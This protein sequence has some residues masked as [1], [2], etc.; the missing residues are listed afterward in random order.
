VPEVVIVGA[1]VAGLAAA[2]ALTT[3]GVDVAVLEARDRIGGRIFTVRTPGLPVPVEL[4]AE[5]L[6]GKAPEV[7]E[8]V[9]PAG[10]AVVEVPD[11][12]R[13]AEGGRFR[14]ARLFDDWKEVVEEMKRFPDPDRSFSDFLEATSEQRG[15]A[16]VEGFHAAR[17]ERISVRSLLDAERSAARICGDRLLRLE[18]GYD[19]VPSLL[20]AGCDA[21]KLSLHRSTVVERV[22]WKP[23][24]VEVRARTASGHAVPSLEAER[25]LF[26][27]PLG[28]M[29]QGPRAHGYVG[30]TPAVPEKRRASLRLE[31]GSVLKVVLRFRTRLWEEKCDPSFAFLHSNDPDFPTWWTTRPVRSTVLTG[32]AGGPVAERLTGRS[33]H[34]VVATALGALA[35]ILDV[36][37]D[38]LELELDAAW[39]HDWQSDPY[40]RGAYSYVPAEG[41]DAPKLLATPVADTLFFAGEATVT[42]GTNGTVHGAI[43]SGQ[44]AALEILEATGRAAVRE[45]AA[46]SDRRRNGAARGRPGSR[47]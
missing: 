19:Q 11:D 32:W 31:M 2:R 15:L 42:D 6:H 47:S 10:R 24:H 28:T 23:G 13:E 9:D 39:V 45:P 44:R 33:E 35:R 5:F 30:L 38:R 46:G 3:S 37:S 22:I 34:E 26:T 14:K 20:L 27:M 43:A 41:K 8:T 17:P 25:V 1:G 18:E 16:Y 40:A 12:H 21:G 7:L 36:G 4:G 29:K